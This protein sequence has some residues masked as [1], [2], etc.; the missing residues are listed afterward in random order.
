[1]KASSIKLLKRGIIRALGGPGG[2]PDTCHNFAAA[3]MVQV[4]I[5]EGIKVDKDTIDNLKK[6]NVYD[7]DFLVE[8]E[9]YKNS[10]E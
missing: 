10:K 4:L 6:E 1:M 3:C 2:D 7:H 9:E 5:D 8:I